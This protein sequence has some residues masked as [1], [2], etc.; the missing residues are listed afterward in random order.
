MVVRGS[1]DRTDE[2]IV[3]LSKNEKSR[4]STHVPNIEAIG[5]P[6]FLISD[7][8]KAFNHLWLAFIKALIL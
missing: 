8:K 3:D 5:E 7:A 1:A 4:K 2:M 6:K